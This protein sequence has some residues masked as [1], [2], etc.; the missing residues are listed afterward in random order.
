[1]TRARGWANAPRRS[2]VRLR[3][4]GRPFF[5]SVVV[6]TT[7]TASSGVA[8]RRPARRTV[9]AGVWTR[10]QQHPRVAAHERGCLASNP[11]LSAN[12]ECGS[13]RSSE[14]H[15]PSSRLRNR[16]WLGDKCA[17]VRE[18]AQVGSEW[19]QV[20]CGGLDDCTVTEAG[21]ELGRPAA[22]RNSRATQEGLLQPFPK[23]VEDPSDGCL[24][25]DE[26][27]CC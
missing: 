15:E 18:G 16:C 12:T 26:N 9:C 24:R 6:T 10:G 8:M 5:T 13:T 21:V 11:D 23:A 1:V 20:A 14:A 3:A 7:N 22:A 19:S 4:L 2:P 17:G 25:P 27:R